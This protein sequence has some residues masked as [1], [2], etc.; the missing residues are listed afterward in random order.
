MLYG[1]ITILFSS[2][3]SF[4]NLISPTVIQDANL[5]LLI[6]CGFVVVNFSNQIY[7]SLMITIGNSHHPFIATTIGLNINIILAPVFIFDLH[8][9]VMDVVIAT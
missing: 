8:M 6:T 5:Y 1:L 2:N 4:F 7:T 3:D 9:G